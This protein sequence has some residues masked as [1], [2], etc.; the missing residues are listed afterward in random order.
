[1]V[2]ATIQNLS[3]FNRE[4]WVT[5][6]FPTAKVQD[7]GIECKFVTVKGDVWRA[8]KGKQSGK[9]TVFRIQAKM[10][11]SEKIKGELHNESFAPPDAIPAFTPHQWVIDDPVALMPE[12]YG[13]ES[14]LIS[15]PQVVD[16]SP[17]HM[18]WHLKFKVPAKGLIF[19]WWADMLHDDP[20][21]PC[22]GK[23][24]WSDRNDPRANKTFD[25]GELKLAIGEFFVMDFQ[26][27]KGIQPPL[28]VDPSRWVSVLNDKLITLNDGAGIPL[29]LNILAYTNKK[30]AEEHDELESDLEWAAKSIKNMQA[31]LVGDMVGA[32]N[33]W[34]G[35]WCAAENV[36][37]NYPGST[38]NANADAAMFRESM[39]INFGHFE[40]IDI[41]IGK[42]PGQT[43]KQEDFGATKG[44]HVVL[45]NE[46]SFIPALQFASYYELFR[47]INHYEE[48][49]TKLTAENHPQWVTW[50]GRTHWHPGV[51]PDRIG[52]E[53]GD[54]PPGTGWWG[55]DDQHRS[56]NNFAAYA[57]LS[58]DP[59]VEDQM[60]HQYETDMAS[61]RIKFPSYGAGAAR[62]QGRQIGCWAQFLALTDDQKHQAW[63]QLIDTRVHQCAT[64]DTVLVNAPM[65]VLS[66]IPPDGRKRIYKDGQLTSTVSM[67]EHGLALVGLYKAYK[68]NPTSELK[69]LLTAISETMLQFAWFTERGKR[70]VVGDIMWNDGQPVELKLS[71]G[72]DEAGSNPMTQQFVY[73]ENGRGINEW[74]MAGL[75]VA[76]EFLNYKNSQ[77]DMLLDTSVQDQED[78]EWRAAVNP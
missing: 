6:T 12:L 61:Y 48:D 64:Q 55:Y 7:F 65:K 43:G 67:W 39:Y 33:E 60:D 22:K 31:A 75:R 27:R 5:V 76:R 71:N 74:T 51:S 15:P 23:I 72:W 78:A 54:V 29:S 30:P 13:M 24:I 68:N 35:D 66:V 58:D 62:A 16:E 17:A 40:P 21:M 50:S 56:Q 11:G 37:E 42:T 59:L 38:S 9:K 1:M 36:P 4:H 20:V 19:E 28:E 52:K 44:T 2:K 14:E 3:T 34:Q 70:F 8:V 18:R 41:G 32:C 49:G 73:S 45:D 47:G 57:M 46:V 26:A 10:L 25:V 69:F 53:G 63:K 77:L